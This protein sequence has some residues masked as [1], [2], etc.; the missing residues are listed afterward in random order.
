MDPASTCWIVIRGAAAGRR[1]DREEFAR[2]YLPVVHGYLAARWRDSAW[3]DEVDDAA[4]EVFLACLRDGG[5]LEQVDPERGSDFRAFLFGVARNVARRVEKDRARRSAREG[6]R[7]EDV[8]DDEE[9]FS[10]FFDR[11]WAQ[12]IVREAADALR[13]RL[14]GRGGEAARRAEILRLRFHEGLPIREIARLWQV[15]AAHLHHEYARAREEF[16]GALLEVVAFHRPG[17]QAEVEQECARLL[18][19]LSG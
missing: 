11:A 10:T 8:E 12:A 6:A 15:E 3:R 5:A 18:G 13:A 9:G 14:A 17:P 16:R 7:V 1:E 2:R 19:L 4:Q